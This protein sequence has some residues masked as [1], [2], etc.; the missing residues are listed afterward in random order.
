MQTVRAAAGMPVGAATFDAN[1]TRGQSA[2]KFIEM[3]WMVF[4]VIL[5]MR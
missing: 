1:L 5:Q 2:A 3:A 4:G